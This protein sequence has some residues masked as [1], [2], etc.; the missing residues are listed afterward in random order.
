MKN[1]YTSQKNGKIYVI[2]NC[3]ETFKV[4]NIIISI[5]KE[6][7]KKHYYICYKNLILLHDHSLNS[8]KLKELFIKKLNDNMESEIEQEKWIINFYDDFKD[9]N[10]QLK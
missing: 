5:E 2:N 3:I 7:R 8:E 9:K 4:N 10:S 6:I 1:I